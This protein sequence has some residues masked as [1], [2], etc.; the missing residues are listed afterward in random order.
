MKDLPELHTPEK[1]RRHELEDAKPATKFLL[2]WGGRYHLGVRRE[3]RYERS[4]LIMRVYYVCKCNGK[5]LKNYP[6]E[7]DDLPK[8]RVY[9]CRRCFGAEGGY[10]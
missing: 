3:L 5:Q 1:V 6:E 2:A 8:Y 9:R 4:N 10:R 7:V